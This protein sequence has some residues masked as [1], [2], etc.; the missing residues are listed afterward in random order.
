VVVQNRPCPIEMIGVQDTFGES[1]EPE[2]LAEKYGLTGPYIAAAARRAVG[3]KAR[4]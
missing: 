2:E 3:R 4:T 1:G